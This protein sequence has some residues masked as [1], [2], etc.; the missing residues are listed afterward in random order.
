VGD[1]RLKAV[2][3]DT[4]FYKYDALGNLLQVNLP[5]GTL[6]QYVVD[7]MGRRIGKKVNGTLVQGFLYQDQLHPAA[8]L[9]GSGTVVSRFVYAGANSPAY[10]IKGG[11][12]YRLIADQLGSVRLV[13]NATDGT[14]A[15]RIDYDEYGVVT[16]NT[17]PGF[18]P[19]GFAGGLYETQTNLVRFGARDYDAQTG[20]WAAKDPLS[21]GAGDPNFYR[22]AADDPVNSIDPT[23]LSGQDVVDCLANLSAGFGD[24]VTS[25]WGVFKTSLTEMARQ[26]QNVN[27]GV[28]HCSKCYGGG[29]LGADAW[30]G[31]LIGWAAAEVGAGGGAADLTEDLLSDLSSKDADILRQAGRMMGEGTDPLEAVARATRSVIPNGKVSLLGN[32]NGYEVFGSQISGTGV[33]EVND[34]VMVV[35]RIEQGFKVLGPLRY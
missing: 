26:A 9:D 8:E 23:G 21:F 19:F 32:M 18:Q 31:A 28:D 10:M 14:V 7:G 2:G 34:V 17:N 11:V 22:Y 33:V 3:T 16:A 25:L 6:I 24:Q 27:D 13:V 35:Q 15:Q 30:L 12:A 20:R 1:L 29:R 5:G 4:T